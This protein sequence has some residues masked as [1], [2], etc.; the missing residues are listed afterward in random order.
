MNLS[1]DEELVDLRK[2]N[3]AR[4]GRSDILVAQAPNSPPQATR[5]A[6]R[7]AA[8]AMSMA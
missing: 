2:S 7:R 8:K 3:T 5:M 1:Q 6:P 4:T